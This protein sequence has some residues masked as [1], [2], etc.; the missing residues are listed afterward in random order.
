MSRRDEYPTGVPCFV[1]TL[2]TD[3]DAAMRFYEGI[4]GW[5]FAGP[6]PMPGDPP[7]SYFVA[8][9]A[10]DDVAG[11]GS[12]PP[13]PAPEPPG[14]NTHIAVQSADDAA[15]RA[16]AAGGSVVVAPVDAAPAGR[17]A[18]MQDPAGAT[19]CVWEA[20]ARRGAARVNEPSAWAM[21]LLS[22]D[23]PDVAMSFYGELF[24]WQAHEF[25]TGGT[26]ASGCGGSRVTS[27]ASPSSRSRETW[28]RP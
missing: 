1:D 14:W 9:V 12:A 18:V 21:S 10:G 2:T 5:E 8:R 23:D 28:W 19:F 3:V 27:A 7:G 15:T 6:G 22:T 13:E 25:D 4:F 24:G 16:R 26:T 20:G 17:L 11:V